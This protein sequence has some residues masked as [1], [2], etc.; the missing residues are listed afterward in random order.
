MSKIQFFNDNKPWRDGSKGWP[1][2]LFPS[3]RDGKKQQE[4]EATMS[5]KNGSII[6]RVL[7]KR[8]QRQGE[9]TWDEIGVIEVLGSAFLD[10]LDDPV[11]LELALTDLQSIKEMRP[12]LKD[13]DLAYLVRT[14]DDDEDA[15]AWM[16]RVERY[17]ALP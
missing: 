9:P 7:R 17:Q 10:R 14:A 11:M 5:E 3:N 12:Y 16:E 15:I 4:N 6:E 2:R 1:L 8:H 13:P